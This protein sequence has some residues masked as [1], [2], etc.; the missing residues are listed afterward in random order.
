MVECSELAAAHQKCLNCQTF[1]R[2]AGGVIETRQG[3][4][5]A[6]DFFEIYEKIILSIQFILIEFL[7][8]FCIKIISTKFEKKWKKLEKNKK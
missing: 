7:S 3:P 2:R 5:L 8:Y 6:A 1:R 4:S